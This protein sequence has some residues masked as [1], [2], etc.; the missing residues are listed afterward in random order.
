[1]RTTQKLSVR[2]IGKRKPYTIYVDKRV[3]RRFKVIAEKEYGD[4]SKALEVLMY[5]EVVR[6]ESDDA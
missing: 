1:M 6:R 5:A 3:W 4:I 2:S